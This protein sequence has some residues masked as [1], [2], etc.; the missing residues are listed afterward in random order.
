MFPHAQ[1]KEIQRVRL[2]P[3]ASYVILQTL[4]DLFCCSTFVSCPNFHKVIAWL[5]TL[6]PFFRKQLHDNW[7]YLYSLYC[8]HQSLLTLH[9]TQ[10]I[11]Q[12]CC[13]DN[14]CIGFASS[15][16]RSLIHLRSRS[17]LFLFLFYFFIIFAVLLHSKLLKSYYMHIMKNY[18][19][20]KA[21]I[22]YSFQDRCK[23][24]HLCSSRYT[25]IL[26]YYSTNNSFHPTLYP[27]L[28]SCFLCRKL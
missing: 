12:D 1:I 5:L 7:L 13:R 28:L 22:L 19:R 10:P 27:K 25:S 16:G 9:P 20:M 15:F 11:L 26:W 18:E 3:Q 8:S 23:I 24:F 14:Y 2:G 17:F 6:F 4:K 21:F